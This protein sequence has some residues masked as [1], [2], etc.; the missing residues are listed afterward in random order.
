MAGSKLSLND[1]FLISGGSI[2][3]LSVAIFFATGFSFTWVLV[4]WAISAIVLTALYLT[5]VIKVQ[6]EPAAKPSDTAPS[7]TGAVGMEVFHIAD[8]KFT[9][10]E[11]AAVCAAYDSKLATHEQVINAF[12][13]GAEWCS[14]GWTAGGFALYPTQKKT[15]E[16]LQ[17]ETDTKKKQACGRPGV[18]GG[19]FNPSTKFGVN[20]YGYKPI[21]HVELPLPPPGTSSKDFQ[22][23][24]NKIKAGMKGLTMNPFSRSE[25]SGYDSTTKGKAR[26]FAQDIGQLAGAKEGFESVDA[27]YQEDLSASGALLS[28]PMG[29]RGD[30]G[31]KGDKGDPGSSGPMGPVGPIGP[32]G[33]QGIAGADLANQLTPEESARISKKQSDIQKLKD[34]LKNVSDWTDGGANKDKGYMLTIIPTMITFLEKQ[35]DF[36]G[37]KT[38]NK[39]PPFFQDDVRLRVEQDYNTMKRIPAYSQD[40]RMSVILGTHGILLEASVDP[41]YGPTTPTPPANNINWAAVGNAVNRGR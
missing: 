1:I 10:D 6:A 19:Y 29:L 8:N 39:P 16:A 9:Y 33:P 40:P 21:G 2:A 23:M 14:Y 24:V 18:N 5:G 3:F 31:P 27:A 13:T 22:A 17:N 38:M 41:M 35:I 12:N 20:C 4:L 15:W 11:A 7:P 34:Y 28:S 37:K 25:W 32:V 30:P 36:I 26:N